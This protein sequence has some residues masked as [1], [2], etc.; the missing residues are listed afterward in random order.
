MIKGFPPVENA[1][2]DGGVVV[3]EV[4]KQ[5]FRYRC[6]GS[7]GNVDENSM[8]FVEWLKR[9]IALWGGVNPLSEL[10]KGSWIAPFVENQTLLIRYN[11]FV[12]PS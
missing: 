6:S 9:E 11:R 7:L 1:I 4:A 10:S 12:Y 8:V 2:L 3:R 5:A